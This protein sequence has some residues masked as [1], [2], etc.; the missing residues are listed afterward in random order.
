VTTNTAGSFVSL[1]ANLADIYAGSYAVYAMAVDAANS[2]NYSGTNTIHVTN[3]FMVATFTSPLGTATTNLRGQNFTLTVAASGGSG[4]STVEF[5]TNGI[6]YFVDGAAPF[7][8]DVA[9]EAAGSPVVSA[10]VMDTHGQ[11]TNVGPI[12]LRV[13]N[14][15]LALTLNYPANNASFGPADSLCA[16]ATVAGGG[17]PYTLTFYTSAGAGPFE[18]L[19]A[20]GSFPAYY[21]AL[22]ALPIGTYQVYAQVTDVAST[23]NSVTNTF[24]VLATNWV[25]YN[26]HN[27]G[28]GTAPNVATYSLTAAGPVGGPLTNYATGQSP[29]NGGA[30]AGLS[31]ALA[32]TL[33]GSSGTSGSPYPGTPAYILWNGRVDWT[34]SALFFDGSAPYDGSVTYTFTNLDASKQYSFRGTF[35]RAASAAKRWTLATIAGAESCTPAHATGTGSP[36][37]VTNGW[38]PYGTN[39][40]FNTQAAWNGG[41]NTNGDLI[42]WDHIVPSGGS[43]S[44]ICSNWRAS[45]TICPLVGGGQGTLD[46][47]SA[48]AFDALALTELERPPAPLSIT[49][50]LPGPGTTWFLDQLVP[51]GASTLGGTVPYTNTV[52]YTNFNNTGWAVAGQASGGSPWMNLGPLPPGSYQ[53]YAATTDSAGRPA[54]ANSVTNSFAVLAYPLAVTLNGPTNNMAF[55]FEQAVSATATVV[56]GISPYTVRFWTNDGSGGP[57]AVAATVRG[58]TGPAVSAMVSPNIV[59]P[60]FDIFAEVVDS[61]TPTPTASRSAA[62]HCALAGAHFVSAASANP[63]SPYSSWDTAAQSIQD[64]VDVAVAGEQILV[65]NGVYATGS[66]YGAGWSMSRLVINKALLVRSINGAEVTIIRGASDARCV[67]LADGAVLSGFTLTNGG[68]SPGTSGGGVWCQSTTALVKDCILIGNSGYQGAGAC[69]GTLNNCTLRGNLASYQGGGAYNCTLNNCTLTGNS[70]SY[71]GS[72]AYGG[73]LNNCIVYYNTAGDNH[74]Y[75][76]LDY[77]CTTPL[78]GSGAGNITNEPLFVDRING[79]LRLQSSSP[80]LDVGN[81]AYAPGPT[82]LDGK[83]R[84]FNGT[85]DLG[86]YEWQP[87]PVVLISPANNALFNPPA[88]L[89]LLADAYTR[90]DSITG[91]AFYSTNSGFLGSALAAP[92][93][94]LLSSLAAG[95]YGFYAVATNSL[96]LIA[97]SP[98]NFVTVAAPIEL[99]LDGTTNTFDTLPPPTQW[100]SGSI[101]S[102][103]GAYGSSVDLDAAV[104]NLTASSINHWLV[105][106]SDYANQPLALWNSV[107]QRIA[108][109][110]TTVGAVV[111][112][113]TLLNTTGAD[114]SGLQVSYDLVVPVAG[115]AE[116]LPGQRVYWSLTGEPGSWNLIGSYRHAG[117]VSF[118]LYLGTWTSQTKLYLLWVDDNGSPSPNSAYA[119]DNVV[120]RVAP[121]GVALTGPTEGQLVEAGDPMVATAVVWGGVSPYTVNFWTNDGVGEAFA[122]A[123]TVSEAAGPSVS[124]ALGV[125]PAFSRCDIFVEVRDSALPAPAICYSATNHCFAPLSEPV[126]L[127]QPQHQRVE[128]GV[129]VSLSVAARGAAPLAYQWRKGGLALTN[130]GNIAG[131]TSPT[132]TLQNAQSTDSGVYSA[133]VTNPEGSALSSNAMLAVLPPGS[134]WSWD[135][136]LG[137]PVGMTL[138]GSASVNGGYLKLTTTPCYNHNEF[139][140]AYINDFCAGLPIAGFRATFKLMLFGNTTLAPADGCSFNLVPAAGLNP[141]PGFDYYEEGLNAGLAVNFHTYGNSGIEV[142][143]L[144]TVIG[145]VAF[146]PS[147]PTGVTDP[148]VA[149]RDV[150]IELYP[151]GTIDVTYG[152]N[153]IFT[154]LQTPYTPMAGAKWV[155]A[156]RCGG[157]DDNHWF[158]DLCITPF[159]VESPVITLQPQSQTVWGG[160]PASFSVSVAGALPF[161]YQW[162]K[163]GTN[164]VGQTNATLT[165]TNVRTNEAG[166]YAALVTNTHGSARSS[167]AVLTVKPAVPSVAV[168]AG[169]VAW[170]RAEGDAADAAGA[171]GG[172]LVNGVTFAPGMVGQAFSLDGTS[173]YIDTP[174]DV[175][176]T[177]MPSTTWE[178]WVFPT[179]VN[180]G[181]QQQI[182]SSDDGDTDRSVLIQLGTANFAVFVGGGIWQPAPV[183]INEWQHIA[184]VFTPSNIEFYKNG[185]RYS[186]GSVPSGSTTMNK[187]QI[188][189]NPG[190]G[191]YLQGL[192]DEV[193]IYNRALSAAEIQAIYDAGPAGKFVTLSLALASPANHAA[194]LSGTS[195][196]AAGSVTGGQGPFRVEYFTNSGGGNLVF[197]SAGSSATG[198]DYSVAL[199]TQPVGTYNIYAVVTDTGGGLSTNSVTNTFY[200]ADPIALTLTSPAN[201]GTF[202]S[203]LFIMATCTVAGGRAP[204]AVQFYSNNVALGTA[205][206]DGTSYWANLGR[207]GI[208]AGY[209]IQAVAT[210]ASGWVNHSAV[211]SITVAPQPCRFGTIRPPGPGGL[212]LC[213]SGEIGRV[214][215]IYTSSNLVSWVLLV[216]RTNT[217]GQVIYTDPLSPCPPS[218]FYKAVNP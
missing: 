198:P 212:D 82:D 127:T 128:P 71:Q 185:V 62:N 135:F 44:V 136:D 205:A 53:I 17:S 129:T 48:Y 110:P 92:Y 74:S 54:T 77:C 172:T 18:A 60:A 113:A 151:D 197:A 208:G 29:T 112:M 10:L 144:G 154:R 148:V 15:P 196:T 52:F 139:G 47:L 149:A 86:A 213:L 190:Y 24:S 131:A 164:L 193:S 7:T 175:Q 120:F 125:F 206:F 66:R 145:R 126:I 76:T 111:L 14:A 8:T 93:S 16:T 115:G 130:G 178:C 159:T 56:G 141:S 35:V 19:P 138:F 32:G 210:D 72:G 195:L 102:D 25:A 40:A 160:R 170:Y 46:S 70:A 22:G 119:L 181:G 83:P 89:A 123:A 163:D 104:D 124:A 171:Y 23:T 73:L 174:L 150:R 122:L 67:D 59:T 167:N 80:C 211:A 166:L 88:T 20:S 199:G 169:L 152:T 121:S 38:V 98:T 99:G 2:T 11:T 106:Q 157:S 107:D 142:K 191:E 132:L 116:E 101:G 55:L 39:L 36:G 203:S 4:I 176:P 30:A 180:Y 173:G 27:R 90:E 33:N 182:L 68:A 79:N 158:D 218:R 9:F 209:Q 155:L 108:T 207:F 109:A 137:L 3:L 153:V 87:L 6:S 204:Y 117:A 162:Q 21:V 50:S 114:Q 214:V 186:Y 13:T 61:A 179:R 75:A 103:A 12:S 58:A 133:L 85:V 202:E 168:P 146:Q 31:I 118:A 140:V 1:S 188:G 95:T 165:L 41:N 217:T 184:V 161:S 187:L 26:D 177:A 200:V 100:S 105:S 134:P 183:S 189:R 34:N 96:D 57:F 65:G 28:A 51:A 69:G 43:F 64:A 5:S 81:N 147:Q 42:G 63:V 91:V 49:L 78:P 143:W 37:I 156:A 216:R 45:Q 194:F 84:I 97:F 94:N 201:G 215:E 192:I